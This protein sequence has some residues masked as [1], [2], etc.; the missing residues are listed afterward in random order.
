LEGANSSFSEATDEDD[1]VDEGLG[2]DSLDEGE[3]SEDEEM[4]DD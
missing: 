1:L 4:M 3:E 2:V